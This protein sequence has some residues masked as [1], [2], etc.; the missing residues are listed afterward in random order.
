[1][2][3]DW[4]IVGISDDMGVMLYASIDLRDAELRYEIRER[5]IRDQDL[6]VSYSQMAHSY[7]TVDMR[8]YVVVRAATYQEAMAKLFAFWRPEPAHRE[9]LE[10]PWR[11]LE[12]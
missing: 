1:M 11:A 3:P 5:E 4:V 7:L 6:L 9:A 12:G 8:K 10:P 2:T